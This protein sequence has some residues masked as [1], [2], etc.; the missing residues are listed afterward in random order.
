MTV[1]WT[2]KS[3]NKHVRRALPSLVSAIK[4]LGKPVGNYI[5]SVGMGGGKGAGGRGKGQ[6]PPLWP[7]IN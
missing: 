3:K 4:G 2:K 5:F 1:S 7:R 6:L